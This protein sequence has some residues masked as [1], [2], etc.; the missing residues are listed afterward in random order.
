MTKH[1]NEAVSNKSEKRRRVQWETMS[2]R[3]N[4]NLVCNPEPVFHSILTKISLM[5]VLNRNYNEDKFDNWRVALCCYNLLWPRLCFGG[6]SCVLIGSR[7][8]PASLLERELNCDSLSILCNNVRASLHSCVLVEGS[9]FL[10]FCVPEGA[11]IMQ[12]ST[13]IHAG[14]GARLRSSVNRRAEG[15]LA[16]C[17][18]QQLLLRSSASVR[19]SRSSGELSTAGGSWC[20]S[21]LHLVFKIY[22]RLGGNYSIN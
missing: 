22:K 19:L 2:V 12:S 18:H 1:V 15:V 8:F 21:L 16:R 20:R 9:R 11:C 14:H 7:C 3:P 5:Q 10:H 17:S 4:S 6:T 13:W